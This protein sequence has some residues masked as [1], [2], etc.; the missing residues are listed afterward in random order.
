MDHL[1]RHQGVPLPLPPS[2]VPERPSMNF[3][4]GTI[5]QHILSSLHPDFVAVK[6]L[7]YQ[8]VFF[9]GLVG[10]LVIKDPIDAVCFLES[11]SAHIPHA[12]ALRLG[13]RFN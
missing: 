1:H 4:V 9:T 10:S 2:M 11:P 13:V 12:D 5:N 8:P 7:L 6:H 3:N